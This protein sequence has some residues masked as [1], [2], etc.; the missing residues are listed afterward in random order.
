MGLPKIILLA[1]EKPAE[2]KKWEKRNEEVKLWMRYS[3]MSE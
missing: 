3:E 2:K 1:E